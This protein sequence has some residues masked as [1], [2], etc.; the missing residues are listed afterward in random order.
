MSVTELHLVT[1]HYTVQSR[2][3]SR[4][5]KSLRNG[6]TLMVQERNPSKDK[7]FIKYKYPN[8]IT[9]V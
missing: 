5:F 3:T 6:I 2:I 7:A 4:L 1:E 9:A 8:N